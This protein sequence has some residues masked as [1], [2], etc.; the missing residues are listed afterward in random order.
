MVVSCHQPNDFLNPCEPVG[1]ATFIPQLFFHPLPGT[2]IL[3]Y[4][5]LDTAAEPATLAATFVCF[6][7]AETGSPSLQR[8]YVTT[9]LTDV[10][11]TGPG[12]FAVSHS[13]AASEQLGGCG[14]I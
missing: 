6:G 3:G 12:L 13:V 1:P 14:V 9:N 10:H 5:P 4:A 7:I 11:F 8:L 2:A